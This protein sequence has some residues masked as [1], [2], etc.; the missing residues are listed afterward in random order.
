MC[1][2]V[3]RCYQCR[4]LRSALVDG[5]RGKGVR[6]WI[7]VVTADKTNVLYAI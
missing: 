3:A 7:A 5:V 1:V 6:K 4:R 2:H